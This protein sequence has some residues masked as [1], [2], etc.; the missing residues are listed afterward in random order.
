VVNHSCATGY[1]SFGHE[2]GHNQGLH[3]DPAT[4][5]GSSSVFPYAFGYQDPFGDFR[6]IMAYNCP[7]GCV[8]V[9]HF[10]NP[11]ILFNGE[12]TG[13]AS[14]S[15]NAR[16]LDETASVVASFRQSTIVL[17][18]PTAPSNL[19][20]TNQGDNSIGLTWSDNSDDE[21]GFYLERATGD[22]AFSQLAALPANS[23]SYSDTQ[24][25]AGQTYTYRVRAWN[26]NGNSAFS[27]QASQWI[28]EEDIVI[29]SF[30]VF[31]AGFAHVSGDWQNLSE[32]DGNMFSL[33]EYSFEG[34]WWSGVSLLEYYWVL[35]VKPG[36]TVTVHA[37]AYTSSLTE[38]F[39]F[40]YSTEPGSL[41]QNRDAWIDMFVVSPWFPGEL[42]FTL[43]DDISGV[44]F[45]S[46]RDT[47]RAP[48]VSTS[49]TLHIDTLYVRTAGAQN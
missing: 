22:S 34:S 2:L 14:Q 5:G 40:A 45:I 16:A 33:E 36:E 48:N 11:D 41:A 7:G 4:A 13:D 31:G 8:R 44:I 20:T 32:I 12:P 23:S 27:D 49:N 9:N 18:P 21:S 46:A 37:D 43:P 6:T 3:H 24:L 26:S 10:S 28:E 25:T 47:N 1:Y 39:T 19:A 15:N 17:D 35:D 42:S 29:D 38:V 30:P